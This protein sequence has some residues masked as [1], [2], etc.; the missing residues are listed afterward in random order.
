VVLA[1][2]VDSVATVSFAP[3]IQRYVL[4]PSETVFGSTV[5]EVLE[6][7]FEKH[8]HA[9]GYVLDDQDRL[10]PRL[11]L[12]V[13]GV[14]TPDRVSLSEPVHAHAE[15]HVLPMPLDTEYESL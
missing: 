5:Q 14:P 3:F 4:C 7:Y 8:R 10:R 2:E 6:A 15:I 9:R 12:Y 11:C 1:R 13:D